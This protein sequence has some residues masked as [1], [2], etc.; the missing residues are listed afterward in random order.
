M[1]EILMHAREKFFGDDDII[2]LCFKNLPQHM[3]P[4]YKV[5]CSS[6]SEYHLAQ[7]VCPDNK[8][9]DFYFSENLMQVDTG[10]G[11]EEKGII[12]YFERV[13]S[14]LRSIHKILDEENKEFIKFNKE[15][16]RLKLL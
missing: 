1:N 11:D 15:R 3:R 13:A 4:T 2:N 5:F 16:S 8:K 6:D 9:V 12:E 10:V 14:E 7:A